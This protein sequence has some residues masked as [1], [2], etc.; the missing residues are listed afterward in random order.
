MY[1]IG[2]TGGIASGK[3]TV[4]KILQEEGFAIIDAD[5]LLCEYKTLYVCFFT[6]PSVD[7]LLLA[8][9]RKK[10]WRGFTSIAP[11]PQSARGATIQKTQNNVVDVA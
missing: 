9:R 7:I 8:E 10:P 6:V 2:L 1:I 5:G 3:S 4:S 11:R